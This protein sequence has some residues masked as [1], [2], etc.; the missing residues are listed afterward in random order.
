MCVPHGISRA[1]HL[2]R[3]GE[4]CLEAGLF[5]V[6]AAWSQN[7][8]RGSLP[9]PPEGSQVLPISAC[10]PR[11]LHSGVWQSRAV[12]AKPKTT[13]MANCRRGSGEETFVKVSTTS[14][15]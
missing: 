8:W 9:F 5:V 6:V 4:G 10:P 14:C 11:L 12:Y 13:R 3:A 15:F 2:L 1:M 7:G